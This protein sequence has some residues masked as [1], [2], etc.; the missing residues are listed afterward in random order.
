MQRDEVV[1]PAADE[2]GDMRAPALNRRLALRQ[3][4][5]FIVHACDAA[6]E[7]RDVVYGEFDHIGSDAQLARAGDKGAT[8]V[9]DAPWRRVGRAR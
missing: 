1:S 3:E 7:P 5:R 2:P 6:A 8:Q 9:M 4:F